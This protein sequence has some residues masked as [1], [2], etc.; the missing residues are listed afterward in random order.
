VDR[1]LMGHAL[2][3][4]FG[5][6][7]L[8]YMGDEIAT[9]ND[10]SYRDVPDIAHDSRWVHRPRMDWDRAARADAGEGP[11]GR[12]L[13]GVRHILA[14]RRAMP[15]FHGAIPTRILDAGQ[16]GVFAFLRAAPTG[17]V[18]CL[19]NFTER[20]TAVSLD[21]AQAQG[22]RRMR[23]GLSDSDVTAQNGEIVLPPYARV[24]LR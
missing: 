15:E 13:S 14:Q 18:L 8:I 24:W 5:G 2:I 1:I 7:P 10:Y 9:L 19:F 4:S 11:E 16:E 20:W 3:A 17:P 23:D 12:V 21:R 6:I 22:V